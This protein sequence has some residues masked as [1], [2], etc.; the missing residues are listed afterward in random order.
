MLVKPN[1]AELLAWYD[2][3][4]RSLPW[5]ALP[6]M[7]KQDPYRVWLSEIM[8]Q[9]TTVN[10][11]IPYFEAFLARWPSVQA[12]AGA[13]LEEV[14]QA[15]AGLGYYA[16]ARN[17]HACAHHVVEQHG[18]KFPPDVDML[19]KLPGVGVYT[20]AAI[21]A[22]AFDI[23]VGV[24]DGNIERIVSRL[25][26]IEEP[27]PKARPTI[28]KAIAQMVPTARPGDF[29]QAMMDLGASV[30]TP[31]V[32]KCSLCPWSSQCAA[33]ESGDAEHFPRKSAKV[34]K[35]HRYGVAFWLS[36]GEEVLLVRRPAKGLL[37]GMPGFPTTPWLEHGGLEH[38]AALASWQIYAPVV[39]PWQLRPKQIR[40]V[41]THFHLTLALAV[42]QLP[43]KP[44]LADT[45]SQ[46]A[47]WVPTA[48]L[49]NAGLPTVF[50]KLLRL[51]V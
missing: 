39:A 25:F 10:T 21:A 18:G 14:L 2:Q 15:W 50:A 8:L 6:G 28:H 37:G 48:Q 41:F 36:V 30:C 9:Q 35:P 13:P 31:R 7:P 23:P 3:N 1:P 17:L 16:R 38:D 46:S 24:V 11:V 27:L 40:H 34:P 44:A 20:A 43:Q 26:R 51:G 5:R 19:R 4:A 32:P 22:I 47:F 49:G 42:A 33:H 45:L 12:L 29:A